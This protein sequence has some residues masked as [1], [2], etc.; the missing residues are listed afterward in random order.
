[1]E[2]WNPGYMDVSG[3]ILRACMPAIPAGMT[4]SPFSF[5]VGEPK[6]MEHFAVSAL[7]QTEKN[8]I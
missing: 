2:C 1:M 6:I 3:R 8:R 4:R 5:S 7:S